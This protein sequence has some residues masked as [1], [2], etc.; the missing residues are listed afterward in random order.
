MNK[1]YCIVIPHYR[2]H[3]PLARMLPQLLH[4]GLDIFVVDDASGT[5]SLA[6]LTRLADQFR[7]V[8]VVQRN[9]NGG[10]GAA[11]MTG[12]STARHKGFT[13]VVSLD[14]DGQHDP[15]ALPELLQL[16]RAKPN[17]LITGKPV[18]GSDIP[19]L[20]LYGRELTNN[21]VRLVTGSSMIK[22]AMCGLRVYPLG[23]VLPL[24][25]ALGRR[26]R[27]EFD[28][29]ILVRACWAGLDIMSVDTRVVYPED[30]ESHFR[31]LKDNARLV[32]MHTL[33]LFGALRRLGR[34]KHPGR[35]QNG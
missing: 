22:D 35:W 32:V 9:H 4:L 6:Q 27:M 16:S 8:T 21:L 12:L 1:S 18:F 14:A 23:Q 13:H 34:K 26:T 31:M 7:Q 28:V 30:G 29:E 5:T 24:C 11:M 3:V 19:A 15:G 33:L 10:K 20:R 25:A 17:S 2:H